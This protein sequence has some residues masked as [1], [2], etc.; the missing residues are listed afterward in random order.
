MGVA[1]RDPSRG[2]ETT[3]NPSDTFIGASLLFYL[4]FPV[5]SD[6]FLSFQYFQASGS[7][8]WVVGGMVY[9]H[10]ARRLAGLLSTIFT[11]LCFPV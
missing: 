8:W 1:C 2:V 7:I 9:M 10:L 3:R 5:Y 11:C 4:S 6:I